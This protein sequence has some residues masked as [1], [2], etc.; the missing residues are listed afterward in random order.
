MFYIA[1]DLVLK[2]Q[3]TINVLSTLN[4]H[5]GEIIFRVQIADLASLGRDVKTTRG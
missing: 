3:G 2:N 4:N 1:C 5:V